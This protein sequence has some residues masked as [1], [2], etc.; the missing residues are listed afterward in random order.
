MSY[1]RVKAIL[2]DGRVFSNVYISGRFTLGFPD[3]APFKARDIV[4][5][6]CDP[7]RTAS[8]EPVLEKNAT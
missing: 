4:D 6:V 8:G 3:L 5:I 7:G 2:E 1:W